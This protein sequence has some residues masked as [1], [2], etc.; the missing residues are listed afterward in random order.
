MGRAIPLSTSMPAW[1]AMGQPLTY[2]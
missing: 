2:L 1:H